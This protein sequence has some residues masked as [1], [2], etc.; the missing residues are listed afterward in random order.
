MPNNEYTEFPTLPPQDPPPQRN[1]ISQQDLLPNA[2]K[3]RLLGDIVQRTATAS[4]SQSLNNGDQVVF[5]ITSTNDPSARIFGVQDLALYQ[6]NDGNGSWQ[7]PGGGSVDESQ[8][9]VIGPWNDWHNPN[10]AG[11]D[12][13]HLWT[14][15][16]IRNISAG[17]ATTVYIDAW[18]RLISNR[19]S[20]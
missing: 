6:T 9:Q 7:L 20:S 4:G 3:T 1:R 19:P 15:V 2:V 8:W 5:T 10:V 17:A 14:K 11:N 12:P 16:Y 18:L 13:N